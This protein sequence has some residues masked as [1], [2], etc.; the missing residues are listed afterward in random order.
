MRILFT[1]FEPFGGEKIN[2]ALEAV[3]RLDREIAGA[4]IIKLELPTVFRKSINILE[5]ALE[6]EKPN[7]VICIGQ[8]GGRDR[9]SI[10]RV[11]INISDA[12]IPDNE[13]SRPID[14]TIFKDGENAYFSNL[15]IKEIVNV[16]K[17]NNIPGEISN[18]AGT[19]VCNHIM[20][21]LLYNID[22]KYPK[23][24]GGFIHIPYLPEQVIDKANTPSMSLD[25]IIKGLT[26]TVETLVGFDN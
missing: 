16:L 8:A 23:V 14:E 21:G 22:K 2:P 25:N 20:Y 1:G 10:E 17:A 5:S 26:L 3:K 18:S 15:P 19:Y 13:G 4:E 24:K 9:I 7:A 12:R 11:A 6:R